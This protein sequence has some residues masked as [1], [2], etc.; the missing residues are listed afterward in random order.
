M[1][2][3][4]LK[5]NEI[6]TQKKRMKL[7]EMMHHVAC[8][9]LE[10]FPLLA[11]SIECPCC[12]SKN[13]DFYVNKFGYDLD[14]CNDC[15][16]IFTNPMPSSEALD[17]YY[18][19]P[20][21]N[22]ENEFF[23][24]SFEARIPIFL[25]RLN[26]LRNVTAGKNI[27]DIGTAVGILLEA[28]KRYEQHFNIDACDLNKTSCDLLRQKYPDVKVFNENVLNLPNANYEIVTLWDTFEHIPNVSELLFAIKNQ[29]M[30]DGL[31]VFS[32]PNTASLEWKVMAKEHVQLLPPGHVNLY[33]INNIQ[34]LLKRNGFETFSISTLNPSLDLD[35]IKNSFES[36]NHVNGKER[37]FISEIYG[38]LDDE[39]VFEA[40]TSK[41]RERKFAG[42]MVIIAKKCHF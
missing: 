33:N 15:D 19:S 4:H 35:Y 17:Y 26:L 14:K 1:Q 7:Q 8:E 22:F 40:I 29:L 3:P 32:T 30:V 24:D 13:I 2:N 31:F 10:K 41:L 6:H 42:N 27:L 12:L 23:L 20:F 39:C 38:L 18:N 34:D 21:K 5:F 37:R 28:N 16:H 25:Q 36:D 11:R 9:T